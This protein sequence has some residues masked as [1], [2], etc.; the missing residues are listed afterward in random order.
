M[1]PGDPAFSHAFLQLPSKRQRARIGASDHVV[2]AVSRGTEGAACGAKLRRAGVNSVL[3]GSAA[4]GA[5]GVHRK[6]LDPVQ[7]AE[8]EQKTRECRTD[9]E[10]Y[11]KLRSRLFKIEEQKDF[12]A[13]LRAS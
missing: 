2:D 4:A 8:L 9:E 11:Y 12:C 6:F 7:R 10:R 1:R 13:N 5:C 3:T